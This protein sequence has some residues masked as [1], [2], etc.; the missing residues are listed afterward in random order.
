[1]PQ[2][3]A[4][5]PPS[6]P[7]PLPLQ[8]FRVDYG[9]KS[10]VWTIGRTVLGLWTHWAKGRSLYCPGPICH[11]A[12]H[13]TP[14]TWKGYSAAALYTLPEGFWRPIVLEVTQ[15]LE[16]DFR[17]SYA[18]GQLWELSRGH[19]QKGKNPPVRGKLVSNNPGMEPPEQFPILE[20]LQLL[21]NFEPIEL[22]VS[23][24]LP[25]R[26]LME[27]I[28]GP[29]PRIGPAPGDEGRMS[30]EELAEVRRKMGLAVN[31]KKDRGSEPPPK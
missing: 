31:P 29:A 27:A 4:D 8:V 3:P 5:R 10:T 6:R 25:A 22:S 15:S 24:P 13:A 7:D 1:M 14:R 12:L 2:N 18:R 17:G 28:K 21:F 26:Q 19:K 9:S 23:N 16:L 11:P 30:P 20:A